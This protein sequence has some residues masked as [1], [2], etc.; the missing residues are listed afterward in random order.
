ML[1]HSCGI[2][3]GVGIG[4]RDLQV[5]TIVFFSAAE[6]TRHVRAGMLDA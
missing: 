1:R 6:L 5:L 4:V 3:M 2:G